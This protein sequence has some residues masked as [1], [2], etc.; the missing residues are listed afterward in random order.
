MKNLAPAFFILLTS[1]LF[2]QL[3]YLQ[4]SSNSPAV[5]FLLISPDS[6]GSA[7]G[8]AGTATT[9]D[10]FSAYWDPAKAV[11]ADHRDA[12]GI[13]YTPWLRKYVSG[14][15][16][17]SLSGYHLLTPSSAIC[18]SFRYFGGSDMNLSLIE[19]ALDVSYA[20]KLG[21]HFSAAGML[22]GIYSDLTKTYIY[23]SAPNKPGTGLAADLSLYY[24][25]STERDSRKLTWSNGVVLSNVGPKM[26]YHIT[27]LDRLP[28]PMNLRLGQCLLSEP[29]DQAAS[30]LAFS[31]DLNIP[32][33]P[34]G[35]SLPITFAQRATAG[36]GLQYMY[37]QYFFARAGVY[38]Q[39]ANYH[40]PS[41]CT[42][43]IGLKYYM[44]TLNLSYDAPLEQYQP[45]D[46]SIRFGLE[47]D[48]GNVPTN[49]APEDYTK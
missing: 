49:E 11:F 2:C 30:S 36:I 43:G 26:D 27:G 14:L 1:P 40:W 4:V 42:F 34:L 25:T 39:D 24:K 5:P 33:Y 8:E 46:R 3:N 35:T 29:L 45:V 7:M 18:A 16:L 10:A 48:F 37:Y 44:F 38:L 21:E 47:C 15:S 19:T 17:A 6:P 23:T 12:I 20:V 28:L 9:P 32:F 13:T 41:Y 31:T 22:R